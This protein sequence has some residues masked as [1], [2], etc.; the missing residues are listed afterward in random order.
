MIY[1]LSF[2]QQ[3]EVATGNINYLGTSA[4]YF[5]VL[6]LQKKKKKNL[7][8]QS[9]PAQLTPSM[10]GNSPLPEQRNQRWTEGIKGPQSICYIFSAKL[11]PAPPMTGILQKPSV[12]SPY[13]NTS[14]V[15]CDWLLLT[16]LPPL[17]CEL[18][19]GM[20]S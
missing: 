7:R 5:Q 9:W 12:F 11:S 20:F 19:E 10:C 3:W 17:G 14:G 8:Q 1:W 16:I 6:M 4:L 2:P 15:Y 18:P 13:C